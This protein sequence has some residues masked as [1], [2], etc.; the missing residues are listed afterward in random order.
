MRQCPDSL[1]DPEIGMQTQIT[2]HVN[3]LG[4]YKAE[5]QGRALVDCDAKLAFE[6]QINISA[7]QG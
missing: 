1:D 5:R 2:R 4:G 3:I 7:G 6:R